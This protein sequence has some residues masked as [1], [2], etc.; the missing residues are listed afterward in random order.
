MGTGPHV[1]SNN[2]VKSVSLFDSMLAKACL[3]EEETPEAI[4]DALLEEFNRDQNT[5][6]AIERIAA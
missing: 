1:E 2:V 5:S 3:L 6:T 4:F